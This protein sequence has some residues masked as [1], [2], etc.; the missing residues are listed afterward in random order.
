MEERKSE[1]AIL[2]Y[3]S[4]CSRASGMLEKAGKEKEVANAGREGATRGGAAE[5]GRITVELSRLRGVRD[6][7]T[8]P[9]P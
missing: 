9:G 2:F 4:W 8:P 7:T 6:E 3:S 5:K 1:V